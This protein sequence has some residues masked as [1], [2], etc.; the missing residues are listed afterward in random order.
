MQK[1]RKIEEDVHD[2]DVAYWE[3]WI[4]QIDKDRQCEKEEYDATVDN[5]K[6][7]IHEEKNKKLLDKELEV[8]K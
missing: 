8:G 6:Q 5:S 4:R 3:E 7:Q 2:I 1:E